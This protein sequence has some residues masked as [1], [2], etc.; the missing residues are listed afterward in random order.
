MEEKGE[1]KG[2]GKGKREEEEQIKER[3]DKDS[4]YRKKVIYSRERKGN[5][6]EE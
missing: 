1:N 2:K 4:K 5:K 6:K 3:R